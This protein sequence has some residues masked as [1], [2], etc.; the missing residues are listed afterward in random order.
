MTG[1]I[2][3]SIITLIILVV[4]LILRKRIALVVTLFHEAGKALHAMPYLVFVPLLVRVLFN[5]RS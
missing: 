4:L 1:A 5:I 2:F 3:A